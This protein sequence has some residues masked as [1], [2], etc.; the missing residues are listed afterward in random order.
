MKILKFGFPRAIFGFCPSK[1]G[2]IL[3]DSCDIVTKS[4][5]KFLTPENHGF[6]NLAS[7]NASCLTRQTPFVFLCQNPKSLILSSR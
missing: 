2:S 3:A 1:K 7:K 6:M 4:M 5:F